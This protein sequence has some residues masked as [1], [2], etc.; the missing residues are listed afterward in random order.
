VSI[1]RAL[2]KRMPNVSEGTRRA[3]FHLSAIAISLTAMVVTPY[4]WSRLASY[5]SLDD[6][7]LDCPGT[8]MSDGNY[9]DDDDNP[10]THPD[11]RVK[12]GSEHTYAGWVA[13]FF[14]L[15]TTISSRVFTVLC[16]LECDNQQQLTEAWP[17]I[18]KHPDVA[19][20]PSEEYAAE[21]AGL[22]FAGLFIAIA[23]CS[24]LYFVSYAYLD[25][26]GCFKQAA[27]SAQERC[28]LLGLAER[29]S[30]GT[31]A[32]QLASAGCA[33]VAGLFSCCGRRNTHGNPAPIASAHPIHAY[34]SV[35]VQP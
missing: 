9:F 24:L 6:V 11:C 21:K 10:Y 30:F 18:P 23:A 35:R 34:Q 15:T 12:P 5:G 33:R 14:N 20:T 16:Q 26:N 25:W 8:R 32:R 13:Q 4:Y 22:A 29:P 7:R 27:Y 17:L 31:H 2:S 28:S 19:N 3:V 1:F